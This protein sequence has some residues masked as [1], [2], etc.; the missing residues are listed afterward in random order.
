MGGEISQLFTCVNQ[1]Q[2]YINTYE[3][4]NVCFDDLV[5]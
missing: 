5:L 4:E 1:F 2:A 3:D